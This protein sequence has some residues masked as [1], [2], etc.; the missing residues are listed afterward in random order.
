MPRRNRRDAADGGGAQRQRR[1]RAR[2]CWQ[3]RADVNARERDRGQTALMWAVVAAAPGRRQGAAREPAPTCTRAPRRGRL[4]VM[5]DQGP[6]RAVKTSAQDARQIEAGG[7]TALLFAAQ[8]GDAE[9]ARLLLAAGANA[10]DTAATA[11]RRW[12]WRRS[13]ATPTSHACCSTP[14]PTRMRPAP[15]TPPLHAAA[16]R[17]DVALVKALLAKGANPNATLTKGSPV[18][19]FG[20]QWALPTPFIGAHAAVRR[21]GVS[22]SRRH[23]R[24]ARR[25]RQGRRSTLAERHRAPLLA[26]AGVADRKGS[27]AVGSRPLEHHRQRHAGRFRAPNVTMR[28]GREAA[29]RCRRRRERRPTRCR[30]HRAACARRLANRT[31]IDRAAGRARRR[32]RREEQEPA[33]RRSS[34]T[35]PRRERAAAPAS[36]GYPEAE[37]LLRKLGAIQQ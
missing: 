35:M 18:R 29:A 21:G 31:A 14:A 13:P 17:G 16:L 24:A 1:C 10:N 36:P 19:R 15:A 25:R 22:R 11:S 20:S 30:R 33:R 26:A 8:T 2:C 32:S 27:A 6:R 7:S 9:S 4:T 34:L 5:L 3:R 28:G 12:C 23:A 37:A